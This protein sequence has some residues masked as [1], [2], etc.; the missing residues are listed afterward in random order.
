MSGLTNIIVVIQ[1]LPVQHKIIYGYLFGFVV[2]NIYGCYVDSLKCLNKFRTGNLFSDDKISSE[3][4]AA[5]HGVKLN[6]C[7]R[8]VESVIFP[9]TV[10]GNIVPSVV[11]Y[12]NKKPDV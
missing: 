9:V 11:L 3:L 7:Q 12:F 8:Y 4:D 6:F 1:N 5:I 10:I 2:F